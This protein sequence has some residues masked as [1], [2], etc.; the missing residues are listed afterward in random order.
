MKVRRAMRPI[1]IA[2]IFHDSETGY[3]GYR[4][5]F[6][7]RPPHYTLATHPSLEA[8][9]AACDP[10]GERVWEETS[11]ADENKILISRSYKPGSVR[12]LLLQTPLPVSRR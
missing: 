3:F 6:E 10:H 11:D 8:A 2:E 1:P 5:F 12:D 4:Y 7:G 9:L